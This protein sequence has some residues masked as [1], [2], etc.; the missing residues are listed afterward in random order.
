[1]STGE[2]RA[3]VLTTGE[4]DGQVTIKSTGFMQPQDVLR[5]CPEYQAKLDEITQRGWDYVFIQIV[6]TVQ[7]AVPV[8][9]SHYRMDVRF[10]ATGPRGI[11]INPRYF[12][13]LDLG[14]QLPPTTAKPE[15]SEFRINVSSKSFPRAACVDLT[16][17]VVTYI[18]DPFW[19]WEKGWERDEKKLAAAREVQE[20]ASWLIDVKGFEL[21]EAFKPER[22]A[23]LSELFRGLG[24]GPAQG[25][26]SG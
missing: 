22:Y 23:E 11:R 13:E 6:G 16:N 4:A 2:V 19:R 15:I 8:E 5:S 12:L 21:V 10:T 25:E 24:S 18:D 7:V 26:G 17:G 3:P 1:M 20:I 14:P 9:R